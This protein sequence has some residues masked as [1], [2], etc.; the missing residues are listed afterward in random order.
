M[1]PWPR[2]SV[3]SPT[4]NEAQNL[5]HVLGRLPRRLHGVVVYVLAVAVHPYNQ[6]T[7]GDDLTKHFETARR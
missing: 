7:D 1:A 3:I 4:L 2:V 6:P 5:P